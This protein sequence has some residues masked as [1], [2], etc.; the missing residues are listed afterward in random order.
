M[1]GPSVSGDEVLTEDL[2]TPPKEVP[3]P[4]KETAPKKEAGTKKGN[5]PPRQDPD[6]IP[7]EVIKPQEEKKNKDEPKTNG[8]FSLDW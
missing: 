7:M 8:Q 2:A 6:D 1:E 3:A 4:R 5:E